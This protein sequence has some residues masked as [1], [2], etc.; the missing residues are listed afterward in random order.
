VRVIGALLVG[1]AA[2]ICVTALVN[3]DDAAIPNL[4]GTWT[5][6]YEAYFRTES[7]K[8]KVTLEITEQTGVG[9]RG[10]NIWHHLRDKNKPL[11]IQRGKPVTSDKEPIIGVVG[12]DGKSAHIVEHGDGGWIEAELVGPDTMRVIYRETGDNALIYRTELTRQPAAPAGQ[13]K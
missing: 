4:K 13:T 10:F 1:V 12:F 8:A 6:E 9:F 3:A 7:T 11:A 2:L 5:G